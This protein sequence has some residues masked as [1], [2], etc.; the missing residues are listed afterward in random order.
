MGLEIG[1]SLL[2]GDLGLS[3]NHFV[4]EVIMLFELEE[5]IDH[6]LGLTRGDLVLLELLEDLLNNLEGRLEGLFSIKI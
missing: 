2:G 4:I 1:P 3:V 5:E 6:H